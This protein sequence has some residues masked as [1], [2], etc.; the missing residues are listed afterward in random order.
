MTINVVDTIMD[1]LKGPV[2]EQIGSWIGQSP[3][4]TKSA[5]EGIVPALLTGLLGKASKPDGESQL[6]ELFDQVDDSLLDKL[7]SVLKGGEAAS[8]SQSGEN[9]LTRFFGNNLVTNLVSAVAK[10]AGLDLGSSK[11]LLGLL[12]PVAFAAIKRLVSK[13]G[14]TMKWLT[15]LLTSQKNEVARAVPKGL[16]EILGGAGLSGLLSGIASEVEA[17]AEAG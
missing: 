9:L 8:V 2:L 6:S 15:N 4:K 13:G 14:L 3:E 10:F 17:A 16:S 5:A 1:N 7:G 11:S 12:A